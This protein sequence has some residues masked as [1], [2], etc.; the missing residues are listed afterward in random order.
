[1]AVIS[2][3]PRQIAVR[4]CVSLSFVIIKETEMSLRSVCKV[5]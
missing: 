5:L 3:R 1:M 4:S 2:G